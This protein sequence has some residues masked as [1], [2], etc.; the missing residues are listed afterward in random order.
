MMGTKSLFRKKALEALSAPQLNTAPLK[1]V[2]V[3]G[4]LAMGALCALLGMGLLW[5]LFGSVSTYVSGQGILMLGG[6]IDTV[7]APS[8]GRIVEINVKVGDRVHPQMI[9][10][11]LYSV[12]TV[13]KLV[14]SKAEMARAKQELHLFSQYD[15]KTYQ[16]KKQALLEK[17]KGVL[18]TIEKLKRQIL[19]EQRRVSSR[20]KLLAEGLVDPDSLAMAKAQLLTR[21]V[22]LDGF[23][24]QLLQ[25]DS[26]LKTIDQEKS[27]YQSLYT[28]GFDHTQLVQGQ[29]QDRLA[30]EEKLLSNYEGVVT[31]VLRNKG[32]M[33]QLG[34]SVFAIEIES[35]RHSLEAVIFV[36]ASQGKRIKE[37]MIAK[38]SPSTAKKELYGRMIGRVSFVSP[39]PE[40]EL[41]IQNILHNQA[42]IRRLT[43]DEPMLRVVVDLKQDPKTKSGFAWTTPQG[44]QY[45][46]SGG[47][48]CE[49]NVEIEKHAPLL[50]LF[51]FLER[52]FR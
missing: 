31:E 1:V 42:L 27:R 12:D 3:S 28:Y 37:G 52:F 51:P 13:D 45:S 29:L 9:M 33:V 10:G 8:S 22:E 20:E 32:D 34:D 38:I 24:N 2:T 23:E 47:T 7:I 11:R 46:I 40:S 26:N 44:P 19:S 49:G 15:E 43:S 18:T 39:Y 4:W 41:A 50:I 5:G 6:G 16:S 21:E 30:E 35:A 17:K 14:I 36:P 48:L 25:L